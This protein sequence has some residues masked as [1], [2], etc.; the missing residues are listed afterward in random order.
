[1]WDVA[2]SQSGQLHLRLQA[3]ARQE[4]IPAPSPNLRATLVALEE[5]ICRRQS[6]A[7]RLSWLGAKSGLLG[8]PTTREAH[9]PAGDVGGGSEEP[10]PALSPPALPSEKYITCWGFFAW[11]GA[12][13]SI[14]AGFSALLVSRNPLMP[15]NSVSNCCH[16]CLTTALRG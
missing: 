4:R 14:L 12:A 15:P 5:T 3:S 10:H 16:S 6:R 13:L 7:G 11:V 9:Q 1:M 2:S 8:L